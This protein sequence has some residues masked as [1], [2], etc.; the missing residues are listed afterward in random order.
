MD[1]E[2]LKKQIITYMGNKRKFMK[3]LSDIVDDVEKEL[4]KPL[5]LGD[6][7]S[8]SGVVSRLF[9]I[10]SDFCTQMTLLGIQKH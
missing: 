4:N 9:K 6:G 3:I 5:V 10:K 8:G 7:F 1:D 2:F